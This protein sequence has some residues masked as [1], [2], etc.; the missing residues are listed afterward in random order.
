MN[1]A[2]CVRNFVCSLILKMGHSLSLLSLFLSF[3]YSWQHQRQLTFLPMTGFKP[4]TE[5]T[6]LPTEPE[7]LNLN[8]WTLLL[9]L[10]AIW[11]KSTEISVKYTLLIIQN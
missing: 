6:A 5:A 8:N 7:Q 3:I 10:Q 1:A 9:L 4:K 11:K 2:S